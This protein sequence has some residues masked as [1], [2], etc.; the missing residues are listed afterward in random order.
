MLQALL[1]LFL[2]KEAIAMNC[3]FHLNGGGACQLVAIKVLSVVCWT[4]K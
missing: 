1:E 3:G 4:E 2:P